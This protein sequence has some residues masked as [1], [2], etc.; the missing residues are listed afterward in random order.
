MKSCLAIV[1]L[2]LMFLAPVAAQNGGRQQEGTEMNR[3][4]RAKAKFQ[5]LFGEEALKENVSDPE[6]AAIF[7]KFVFGEIFHV[8]DLN[9]RT[10][11]MIVVV[12]LAAQQAMPQLKMHV[13]AAL[14]SGVT[15]VE[16]REAVYQ[17]APFIGFPKT[18]EAVS[19]MNE[20]FAERG[21]RLPLEKQATVQEGERYAAGK[22]IQFP[23]YGDEIREAMKTVPGGMGDD[24][25]RFLTE[26]NFGDFYTRKGLDVKTRELLMRC[27]LAT[28][29]A[30]GQIQAHA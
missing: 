18:L 15:P 7:Q 30:D 19:V 1:I 4:E 8:G 2:A 3:T 12:T 26:V 10:R 14:D 5:E 13:R 24:M 29:G 9:D 21:I 11:E 16:L 6:L 25:A 23:L 20:V 22:V 28:L 27:V 17:C